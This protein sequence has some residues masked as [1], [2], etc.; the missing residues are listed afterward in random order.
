MPVHLFAHIS[1][2]IWFVS[3]FSSTSLVTLSTFVVELNIERFVCEVS[4]TKLCCVRPNSDLAR[5]II[6][7]LSNSENLK[8]EF[9]YIAY[10]ILEA[11]INDSILQQQNLYKIKINI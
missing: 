2:P 11:K 3:L 4:H 10:I 8:K 6:L 7:L 9:Q 1:E 5:Y